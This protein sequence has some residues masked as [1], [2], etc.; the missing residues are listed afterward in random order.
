MASAIDIEVEEQEWSFL[1]DACDPI[2]YATLNL[3]KLLKTFRT[4]ERKTSGPSVSKID[5]KI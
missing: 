3:L 2:L 5:C 1:T 4:C